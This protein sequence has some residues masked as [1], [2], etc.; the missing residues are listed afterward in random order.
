MSRNEERMGAPNL[1]VGS[2]PVV[3]QPSS[4]PAPQA[5]NMSW[6]TPT[7]TTVDLPSKGRFYPEG[8]P[9]HNQ[10]F[11]EITFMTA[12]EEEFLTNK[13]LLKKGLAL[14]RVL[15]SV[16]VDKSINIDTL[17]LGDKSAI[18]VAARVTGFGHEY[19]LKSGCRA[20]GHVNE[21]TYDLDARENTEI[22]EEYQGAKRLPNGNF[23]VMLPRTG[24]ELECRL[25]T[26]ADETFLHQSNEMK[27]KNKLMP[28]PMLDMFKRMIVSV[29]GDPNKGNVNLFVDN[30]LSALDSRHLKD[31]YKEMNPT[32]DMKHVFKC[33]SCD[34]YNSIDIPMTADFFWPSGR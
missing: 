22:L 10:E 26:G 1:Q 6:Y 32:V 5:T 21:F 27:K 20:C 17:F 23:T 16:L 9:L 14:D 18:L 29:N 13:S 30:G 33:E 3:A 4:L 11:V 25:L 15:S 12:K 28:T 19:A 7:T 8:H 24:V 31:V 34:F 2:P